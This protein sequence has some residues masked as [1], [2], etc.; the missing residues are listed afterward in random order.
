MKLIGSGV[1][2]LIVL[3]YIILSIFLILMILIFN[4]KLALLC[5]V[6]VFISIIILFKS[7]T[8]NIRGT[9]VEVQNMIWKNKVYHIKDIKK[10]GCLV[11]PYYFIIFKNND[12]YLFILPIN[13]I[14]NFNIL[15]NPKSYIKEIEC[16][17]NKL[18]RF[19]WLCYRI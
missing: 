1:N 17:L 9:F 12:K 14:L 16:Y 8:I 19:E 5:S 4:G 15:A 10:L 18:E 6:L 13:K 3:T 2:I 11:Y 7:R